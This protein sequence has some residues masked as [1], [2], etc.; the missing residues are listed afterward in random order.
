MRPILGRWQSLILRAISISPSVRKALRKEQ[1]VPVGKVRTEL[2]KR[3][4]LGLV[5]RNPGSFTVEFEQNK[6]LI[7][8][9]QLD[10]TKR[11]RNRIAGY[12]TRL[13][14]IEQTPSQEAA[15][16]VPEEA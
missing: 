2:V 14:V 6:Q 10:V 13:M 3:I 1:V 15:P 11:L 4:A 16:S 8:E 12:I 7:R 9:T 5:D